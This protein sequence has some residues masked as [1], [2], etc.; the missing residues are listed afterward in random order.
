LHPRKGTLAVG[1]DADLALLDL[2]ATR[3]VEA[4]SLHSA[5]DHTPFAG[6]E[7]T[8]WP[9][10]TL[11]RGRVVFKDDAVQGSPGGRFVKRPVALHAAG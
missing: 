7:L 6:L 5:Q 11:L 3:T 10:A 1:G 8:G 2:E 9:T 4:R